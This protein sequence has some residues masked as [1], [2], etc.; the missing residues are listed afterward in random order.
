MTEDSSVHRS[1]PEKTVDKTTVSVWLEHGTSSITVDVEGVTRRLILDTGSNVWILQPGISSN[2]V[3]V[4]PVKPYGG[5]GEA[6]GI[7][8]DVSFVLSGREFSHTFLLCSLPSE[9]AG[10]IGTDF[11][12]GTG[13]MIDFGCN[14]LSLDVSRPPRAHVSPTG[15]TAL[16]LYRG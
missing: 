12:K 10:L 9:A 14:K 16:S 6:V 15:L 11:M 3:K 8:G 13:A 2:E 5:T 7:K 4:T 1:A